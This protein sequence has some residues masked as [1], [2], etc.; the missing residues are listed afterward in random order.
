MWLKRGKP[1]SPNKAVLG[2]LTGVYRRLMNGCH[3]AE[4]GYTDL[5]SSAEVVL[6]HSDSQAAH[7]S[8]VR[9]V[10]GLSHGQRKCL[11]WV[12]PFPL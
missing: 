9:L 12:Q 5:P 11:L 3:G 1:H 6:P 7:V 4:I 8:L 10:A 2:S